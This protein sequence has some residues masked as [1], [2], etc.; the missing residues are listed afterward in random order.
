[1]DTQVRG[2]QAR[3]K[4]HLYCLKQTQALDQVQKL[5]LRYSSTVGPQRWQGI[6]HLT[7]LYLA[8]TSLQL[9]FIQVTVAL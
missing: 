6:S 7:N 3:L 5:D 1:M 9:G 4:M 8:T 2:L